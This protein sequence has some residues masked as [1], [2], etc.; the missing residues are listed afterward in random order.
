[1]D[2]VEI[3]TPAFTDLVDSVARFETFRVADRLYS[4]DLLLPQLTIRLKDILTEAATCG[5]HI[6]YWGIEAA[7]AKRHR[8]SVEAAY[9]AWRD[10]AWI[11]AKTAGQ[12][13]GAKTPSDAQCERMYRT[14][15]DYGGW[16][17]RRSDAQEGAD[18]A[19][20]VLQAFRAKADLIR[21]QERLLR[22]EAGG[23]YFVVEA[24][25]ENIP[26]RPQR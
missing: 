6:L 25:E 24:A 4:A 15:P 16:Q 13:E 14:H 2:R 11:T 3:R 17:Q 19:E 21:T 22:D 26:R 20:A 1:M 10:R 8:E 9:R 7:R 12:D 18:C 5:A 23:P